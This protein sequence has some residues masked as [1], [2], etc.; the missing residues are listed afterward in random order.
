MVR[1][2]RRL[3]FTRDE[4]RPVPHGVDENGRPFW[5]EWGWAG[6]GPRRR[7]VR[8]I[9]WSPDPEAED[10]VVATDLL[11]S[12]QYPAADLLTVYH[13][14]WGIERMFQKVTEVFPLKRLIGSTARA[15]IFQAAFCF[16]LYNMIEVMRAS[17]AEGARREIETISLELLFDDVH[18][19]LVAWNEVLQPKETVEYFLATPRKKSLACWLKDL[20]HDQW[21]DLWLKSPSN[22]HRPPPS[23]A[24]DRPTSGHI[25]VYRALRQALARGS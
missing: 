22:T 12:D 23:Q 6:T 18:R 5:Q 9:H 19:Q 1:W 15:T 17:I 8:R 3:K 10:L 11:D 16:V 25:S 21:S 4:S 24:E 13:R 2:N 14:R 20:L 7:Y